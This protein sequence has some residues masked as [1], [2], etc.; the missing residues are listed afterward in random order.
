MQLDSNGFNTFKMNDSIHVQ[1]L[2]VEEMPKKS[3]T[4]I[5]QC[6]NKI[7]CYLNFHIFFLKLLKK[8]KGEFLCKCKVQFMNNIF[9]LLSNL[10]SIYAR[11]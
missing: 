7:E 1:M 4:I 6:V 10:D 11:C 8:K 3:L 5:V 2:I 9:H